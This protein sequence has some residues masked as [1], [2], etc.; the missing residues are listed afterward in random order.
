MPD[1]N[2]IPEER[3]QRAPGWQDLPN[4][5]P[6]A[7]QEPVRQQPA[8]QLH[9]I[10]NAMTEDQKKDYA[11]VTKARDRLRGCVP[12]FRGPM[13]DCWHLWKQKW[14]TACENSFHPAADTNGFRLALKEALVDDAAVAA[15]S[16]TKDSRVLTVDQMLAEL[17]KIFQP[18][19]ESSMAQREFRDYLQHPDEPAMMYFSAK[20]ALWLRAYPEGGNM[21]T[22]WKRPGRDW[23]TELSGRI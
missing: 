12:K 6:P 2:E 13:V 17:D 8:Q 10:A 15:Q 19:T 18:K 23:P 3:N 11:F 16:V 22:C 21:K 9:A 20:Y 4:G 14:R 5:L 7:Q 1:E